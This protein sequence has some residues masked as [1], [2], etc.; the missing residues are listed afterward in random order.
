[1]ELVRRSLDSLLDIRALYTAPMK[2]ILAWCLLAT[3]TVA[4][5][6]EPIDAQQ[7]T[8]PDTAARADYR[9][10]NELLEKLPK[11]APPEFDETRA[12][13]LASLPL[14][15]LDR[16]QPRPGGRGGAG[17][18]NATSDTTAARGRGSSD[19][20]T[21][22]ARSAGGTNSGAAY[23]WVGSYSLMH[24]HDRLRAFWGCT[25]WHSAV[26]STWVTARL[27]KTFP[28]L[29]LDEL[30][31]EKL[32]AHLGRSNL[33]GELAFFRAT[34]AAIN[35]I[36]SANQ[37]GLFERPYG[38]AWLLKL[39]SELRSWPDSQA[40][41][42]ASNVAPLAA[43][44]SDSLGAYFSKLVEPV[45]SGA[46]TNTAHSM[47]LGLDWADAANDSKLRGAVL[48]A[49][50]RLYLAD[51]TCATQLE[52]VPATTTGRGG[53]GGRGAGR[54]AA[55]DS[56]SRSNA[57]NDLTAAAAGRGTA[58][59]G[60]GGGGGGAVVVSPC[61]AEA[62]LMSRV[63]EPRAYLTWLDRFLPPLQSGRFA[64]LTEPI[65]IPT[66]APA[67]VV[68]GG[69]PAPAA[70]T[71]A[72]ARSAALATERA[73]LAGLSFA[74]A[75]AM[76]RIARA[77]PETDPRVTAWRRLAAIQAER[78]FALMRDDSAGL[79]WVPAQALLYVTLRKP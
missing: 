63:L 25:D 6:A 66:S 30:A 67:P 71:S 58:A 48:S 45:R 61:L 28:R 10:L 47:T 50:R 40:Q 49:A 22:G 18:G 36:P 21:S 13:W 16:L 12:L 7:S 72:A 19:S 42:W 74:R 14:S 68:P 20:A 78:G 24:D 33:E 70:D 46:Q 56:A 51:T 79:S 34:A 2:R 53:R 69:G 4:C 57:P 32:N 38:F 73:R 37:T 17:R 8:R 15:C 29:E 55:S 9:D 64:P 11:V 35:P 60:Q 5:L 26:A 62:A 43:W 1:M 39:Q 59:G 54:G 3:A 52:R 77:L 27:L 75:Q 44:M 65:E 76:E 31:R 41:R 23:F